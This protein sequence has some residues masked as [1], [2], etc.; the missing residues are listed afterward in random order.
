MGRISRGWR[1]TKLS[2][3]VLSKDK[4][5]L[6]L[7]LIA[8]ILN[9]I[10]WGTLIVTIIIMPGFVFEGLGWALSVVVF[11]LMYV[12]SYFIAFFFQAAVVGAAM[13]RLKGG[14]P[15]VSDGIRYAGRVVGKLFLWA[16]VSATVGIIIRALSERAGPIGRFI[17][18]LI[19]LSWAIAS[20]FVI[21]VMVFER[22]GVWKSL[23]RS[24][25]ILKGSWGE[26]LVGNLGLGFIL[27]LLGLAGVIPIVLV[28][29]IT[30]SLIPILIAVLAAIIYWFILA[31]VGSAAQ[32]ILLTALYR[33]AV[34]G[35][36]SE[37]FP[38]QYMVNPWG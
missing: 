35:K 20:Y 1:L 26:A 11:F 12:V 15:T 5:L 38:Q 4:E 25:A 37:D 23:K 22:T 6:V 9:V 3:R 34:D 29:I 21:P 36:V 7:P 19:G 16:V 10:L 8:F 32:S 14:D 30:Q 2:L 18:G 33:Y 27:F 13:I 17:L 24:V 31:L 28:A